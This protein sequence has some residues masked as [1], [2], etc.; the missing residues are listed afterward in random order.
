[1]PAHSPARLGNPASRLQV[2]LVEQPQF[3]F[4]LTLYGGDITLLPGLEAWLTAVIRDA[5]LGPF[6]LP[7]RFTFPLSPAATSA[8]PLPRGMLFV[9][10]VGARG[11]P[12]M[13]LF[14]KTDA[15]VRQE[16]GVG[17]SGLPPTPA[18]R[19]QG[20]EGARSAG[21]LRAVAGGGTAS[22]KAHP[23]LLTAATPAPNPTSTPPPPP[24]PIP[25]R[26]ACRCGQRGGRAHAPCPTT[27]TPTGARSFALSFTSPTTRHMFVM[28]VDG[29]GVGGRAGGGTARSPAQGRP[30]PLL[31]FPWQEL[32]CVVMDFDRFDRDDEVG[33][34]CVKAGQGRGGGRAAG[35]RRGVDA[36]PA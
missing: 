1:M 5:V 30:R 7:G 15:Y 20:W 36:R 34:A 16:T 26:A 35:G 13:D 2:S 12:R 23:P 32:T 9:T 22:P 3:G 29:S 27:T 33:R 6:V 14:S 28:R 18:L 24:L 11:L 8:S 4:E 31:P 19:E 10:A 21:G 25:P 17:D